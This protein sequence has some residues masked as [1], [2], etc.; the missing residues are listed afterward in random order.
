MT[1]QNDEQSENARAERFDSPELGSGVRDT[2]E[3]TPE[4]QQEGRP[5]GTVDEDANPP[6][7]DPKASDTYGGTGKSSPQDTGRAIPPYDGRKESGAVPPASAEGTGG[8]NVGGARGPITDSDYKSASPSDTPGGRSKSPA[9][10][11]PASQ[12]P[13]SDRDDDRVGPAHVPGAGRGESKD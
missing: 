3:D 9:D 12:M 13:E 2:G 4:G 6:M 1:D 10:E 8:A 7:S 11:Q 5:V